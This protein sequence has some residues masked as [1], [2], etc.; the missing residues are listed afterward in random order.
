MSFAS[1]DVEC[2]AIVHDQRDEILVPLGV[3][4]PGRKN[5]KDTLKA[6][7]DTGAQGNIL[8]LRIFRH[9]FPHQLDECGFPRPDATT[10]PD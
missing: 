9:M 8:P 4:L 2:D 6:K 10:P 7:M 1:I 5:A 3:R